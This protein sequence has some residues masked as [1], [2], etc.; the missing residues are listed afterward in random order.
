MLAGSSVF[1]LVCLLVVLIAFCFIAAGYSV[2]LISF[3]CRGRRK[4]GSSG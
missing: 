4:S 3:C 2:L 1:H